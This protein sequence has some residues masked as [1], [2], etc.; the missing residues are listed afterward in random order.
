M[1]K[2]LGYRARVVV[3]LAAFVYAVFLW[4]TNHAG[5]P[6]V[7]ALGFVLFVIIL[8]PVLRSRRM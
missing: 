6:A 8:E 4:R 5:L 2:G 1:A 7:I 3:T